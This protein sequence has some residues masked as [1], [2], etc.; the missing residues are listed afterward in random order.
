MLWAQEI[1][2]DRVDKAWLL[3]ANTVKKF[4]VYYLQ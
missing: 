1:I 4:E 3:Y 2:C